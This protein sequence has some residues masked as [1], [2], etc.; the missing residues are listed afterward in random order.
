MCNWCI[1]PCVSAQDA[2]SRLSLE[3]KLNRLEKLVASQKA[4]LEEQ[5]KSINSLSA[6]LSAFKTSK[7]FLADYCDIDFK[8]GGMLNLT[9]REVTQ[10]NFNL[11]NW[12]VYMHNNGQL[13]IKREFYKNDP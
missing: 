6:E 2:D 7:R 12:G 8:A 5:A 10:L 13:G 4:Q 1:L 11:P 9:P 3:E